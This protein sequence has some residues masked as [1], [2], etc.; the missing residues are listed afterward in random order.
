MCSRFEEKFE[1]EPLGCEGQVS[2]NF[3]QYGIARELSIHAKK[4]IHV[5]YIP[6]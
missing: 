2:M 3:Y 4:G 6:I 1:E 5:H